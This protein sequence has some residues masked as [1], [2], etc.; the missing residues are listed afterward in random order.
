MFASAEEIE[1][2]R[3]NYLA[4]G[5]GYGHAKKELLEKITEF[6]EPHRQKREELVNNMDFVESV[7]RTGA[8]KARARAEKVM[9]RVREAAGIQKFV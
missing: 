4:G 8:E 5:Y 9:K 7:L 1:T 2:M 6:F 3:Q